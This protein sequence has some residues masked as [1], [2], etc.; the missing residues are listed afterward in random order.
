M[1]VVT[2]DVRLSN[3]SLAL[4]LSTTTNVFPGPWE[5]PIGFANSAEEKEPSTNPTEVAAPARFHNKGPVAR[6]GGK[7]RGDRESSKKP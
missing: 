7:K 4:S 1:V 6:G 2:R 5:I 3:R